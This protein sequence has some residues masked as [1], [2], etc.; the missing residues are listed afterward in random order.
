MQ[1]PIEYLNSQVTNM[2]PV[3]MIGC[4]CVWFQFS[5]PGS[6]NSTW[7][8][9]R[10]PEERCDKLHSDTHPEYE[11]PMQTNDLREKFYGVDAMC[12][13]PSRGPAA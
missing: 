3:D 7:H 5:C 9:M 8:L 6:G 1:F 12:P 11:S 13:P 10:H 4:R 2:Q